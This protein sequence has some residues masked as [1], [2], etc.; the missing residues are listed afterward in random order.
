MIVHDHPLKSLDLSGDCLAPVR[1]QLWH[2]WVLLPS[3]LATEAPLTPEFWSKVS[4]PTHPNLDGKGRASRAFRAAR[5]EKEREGGE[6][7]TGSCLLHSITIA[8]FWGE[9]LDVYAMMGNSN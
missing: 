6:R 3:G 7:T 9:L 1:S 4:Q 8:T 2:P 5:V